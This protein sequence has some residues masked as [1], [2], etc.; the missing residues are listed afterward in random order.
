LIAGARLGNRVHPE[1]LIKKRIVKLHAAITAIKAA[2]DRHAQ[3][4]LPVI[5][6]IKARGV[7]SANGIAKALNDV[8]ISLWTA[9]T[10]SNVLG[11]TVTQK[12]PLQLKFSFALWTREMVATLIKDKFKISLSLV[13]V[14]RLLAQLGITCVASGAHAT[15]PYFVLAVASAPA[16]GRCIVR[17]NETRRWY[18]N[19]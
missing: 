5:E 1:P 15:P 9:R 16:R 4:I 17:W 10:V 12:N 11:R 8:G 19:G 2:A 7:T 6:S 14:G 18:S 3:S 13:S